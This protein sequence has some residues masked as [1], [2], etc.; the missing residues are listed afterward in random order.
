MTRRELLVMP[1]LLRGSNNTDAR[2]DEL[3]ISFED[4]RYRAPYK[5]GGKEVDR[6]TLLNVKCRLSTKMGKSATGFAAMPL[7]NVWSFPASDIPYETTLAAMQSLAGKITKITRDFTG[8]AHPLDINK[9]LEP[10]YL[11]AATESSR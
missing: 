6:V 4:F 7:A 5:F 2:I 9:A 10:E 1:F 11:K 3:E 8:Y